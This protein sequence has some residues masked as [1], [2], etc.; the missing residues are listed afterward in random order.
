[1]DC[2]PTEISYKEFDA[3]E[4]DYETWGEFFHK[5][6]YI[7]LCGI[8]P[9]D[10]I[11]RLREDLYLAESEIK[12]LKDKRRHVVHKRFFEKSESMR[13]YII[14]GMLTD[15]AR[16]LIADCPGKR[17]NNLTAHLIHN[18]AY[19]IPPGG[20]GQGASWHTDDPLQS[21]I[22][23]EGCPPLDERVKLPIMLITGMLYLSDCCAEKNG[24][25]HVV[26]GSHR[27]GKEVDPEFAELN[28]IPLCGSA[29]TVV[30]INNQVWHRG[31]KNTSLEPREIVQI[32]YGRRI[33]SHMF[34]SIMNY[35]LPEHIIIGKDKETQELYGFLKGGAYS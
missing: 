34:G 7:K 14:E 26:P 4:V 12:P 9:P 10:I 18:N 23:P 19:I 35:V 3:R 8:I 21:I 16:Y 33:I 6:G 31:C 25:T 17:G 2:F 29:G 15:F 13:E 24:P 27:F 11:A 32:S 22:I 1:M 20:L 5:N 28:C 30:L